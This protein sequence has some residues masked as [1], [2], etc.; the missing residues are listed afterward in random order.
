MPWGVCAVSSRS[1]T[2]TEKMDEPKNLDFFLTVDHADQPFL[3][4]SCVPVIETFITTEGEGQQGDRQR[5]KAGGSAGDNRRKVCLRAL[6]LFFRICQYFGTSKG[7]GGG[8]DYIK[9]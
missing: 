3:R 4:F 7:A 1:P 5:L 9:R 8:E 6:C 2:P